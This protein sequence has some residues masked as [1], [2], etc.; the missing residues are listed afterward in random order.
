MQ[1]VLCLLVALIVSGCAAVLG[2]KQ[3]DFSLGSDPGGADVYLNGNRL[4]KTPLRVKLSNQAN[5]VFVFRRAGYGEAT[6]TLNRGTGAGWV[7]LDVLFG[8][9]PIVVDAATNSWS[10]TKGNEC[11]QTLEPLTGQ[12]ADVDSSPPHVA[13][14]PVPLD[15]SPGPSTVPPQANWIA[16]TRERVYYPVGCVAVE[17]IPQAQRLYYHNE[18]A[19]QAAGFMKSA[20]CTASFPD[21]VPRA[22][23]PSTALV[24]VQDA[25]DSAS[26]PTRH[27]RRGFW[28]NGGLGYGSLGCQDCDGREGGLSGGL[29]L[30]GTVSPKVLLGVGSNGWS[31]SEGDV[32]L[33]AGT[34]TALI[35]LY[36]SSTGG[37]FLLGGL[38]AGS[39]RLDVSGFGHETETGWGALAGLGIDI[40]IG[41]NVSLTPFWNGFAIQTSDDTDANIGQ[42]GLSLTVH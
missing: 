11:F 21:T 15:S 42:I 41:N 25:V 30:G 31:K 26:K 3:K 4:G 9:V 17:R 18:S 2:T 33:T 20:D 5:H 34:L 36:P 37:F 10:Q 32:R 38:G 14:A 12:L 40:R 23:P 39:V 19:V 27:A 13:A 8:L 1:A 29:A 7:I 6:C 22:T 16:D 28:F 24:A 35:R